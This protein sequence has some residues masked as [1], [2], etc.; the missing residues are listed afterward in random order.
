MTK[1]YAVLGA[2]ISGLTV[3]Y[4]LKKKDP[5]AE[6]KVF[7]ASSRP[8]GWI[9]TRLIDGYLCE[10]G[11]RS[12]RAR[13]K[14]VYT[15]QL[16]EELGIQD[17]VIKAD[18]AAH[19]RYIYENNALQPLPHSLTSFLFSPFL[20]TFLKA[21]FKDW[22]VAPQKR[23]DES[24]YTFAERHFG[25]D[26]A[27]RLMDPLTL[28]IYASDCRTLSVQACFPD[29]VEREEIHGS[30]IKSFFSG[31]KA[32]QQL[33][34]WV[35]NM[36]KESLFT[37]KNGMSTLV[38]TLASQLQECIHYHSPVHKMQIHQN[39]VEVVT[40]HQSF[41]ADHV[42]STLSA[43]DL[44]KLLNIDCPATTMSSVS[45]VALGFDQQV[46]DKKGFG[47][48]IPTKENEDILGMVWDSSAFPAQNSHPNQ[49]R[50]TVMID[51]QTPKDFKQLALDALARHLHI[52][53]QPDM[54]EVKV[55]T[56][57]IPHYSIGHMKKVNE[58]TDKCKALSPNLTLLGTSFHGVAVNNCIAQAF[59]A[60]DS[61][62]SK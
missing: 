16:I 50:L 28:G 27:E 46:I 10:M 60:V 25:V 43:T 54:M 6:I 20:P 8:G 13:G 22:K 3:A 19:I 61:E 53:R 12:L 30:L 36:Q 33:S 56:N 42:F 47:Y 62:T 5:T 45:V 26:I 23:E 18:P 7:E 2:G 35:A 31:K 1:K 39:G 59:F 32:K 34:P 24:I 17:E 44:C 55:A 29:W 11:P 4:L 21:A 14:G 58:L 40:E 51:A 52:S 48:L 15:L 37:F 57:A 38:N 49:T 41:F 9:D